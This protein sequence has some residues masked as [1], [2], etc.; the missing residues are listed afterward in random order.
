M[1]E[2]TK[3]KLLTA[4][5]FIFVLISDQFTKFIIVNN[6]E[7]GESI[8]LLPF[9]NIVRIQNYGISFGMFSKIF[10]PII[11][12]CISIII[13]IGLIIYGKKQ[14][15]YRIPITLIIAG[16]L[17]NV[18]DRLHFQSVIDFLDFH[19]N[20]Y[21]WPAFNIA[22]SAIVIGVSLMFIIS[23]LEEKHA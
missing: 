8:N 16:A 1:S 23:Y 14:K 11:F 17:G 19:I 9:F 15:S 5:L 7:I 21:H 22:D 4:F 3:Q 20:T 13:S 18:L 10:H 12:I 6:M 2:S